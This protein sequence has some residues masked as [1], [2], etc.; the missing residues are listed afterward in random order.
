MIDLQPTTHHAVVEGAMAGFVRRLIADR[1]IASVI[2]LETRIDAGLPVAALFA[3]EAAVA[4]AWQ[5]PAR[6]TNCSGSPRLARRW[7]IAASGSARSMSWDGYWPSSARMSSVR[8]ASGRT[9]RGRMADGAEVKLTDPPGLLLKSLARVE[10]SS[11]WMP[12]PSPDALARIL[13]PFAVLQVQL[14]YVELRQTE[15]RATIRLEAVGLDDPRAGVLARRLEQSPIVLGV[16]QG[17][18]SA[19]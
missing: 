1:S 3:V 15:A 17:W 9:E 19:E 6:R 12:K 7:R 4:A 5:A 2:R 10:P 16:S 14:A 8:F 11:S 18:R 13:C